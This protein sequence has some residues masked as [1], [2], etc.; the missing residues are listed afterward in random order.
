MTLDKLK[1]FAL[2]LL[3]AGLA[4]FGVRHWAAASDGTSNLHKSPAAEPDPPVARDRNPANAPAVKEGAKD[5]ARPVP[6]RRR[7]AV[8]RLPVGTFVKE[9]EVAPYGSGRLAWTYEEDRVLGQIEGD[10]M[11][12]QFELATEAEFSLSSNGTIYGLLTG[13]RLNHLRLPEGEPFAQIKPF[14]GL[15][16]AVEPLVND[17]LLDVPFSYQF[18]VQGDRLVISNFRILLAGPNP[19]GK[20]GGIALGDLG[21]GVAAFQALGTALEGTYTAGEAKE[22]PPLNRRPLFR[23]PPDLKGNK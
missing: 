21:I 4:G 8:I 13:V 17:M 22:K 7:E 2:A 10:I 6:G 19:L 18:R 20:V 14:V 16:P 1:F 9:V 15:W 11:G 12:V 5:D 23:K 3:L